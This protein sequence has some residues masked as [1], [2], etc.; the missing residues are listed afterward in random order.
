[1]TPYDQN[2]FAPTGSLVFYANRSPKLFQ[3]SL[4]NCRCVCALDGV[5]FQERPPSAALL[6]PR[7]IRKPLNQSRWGQMRY[8]F[9]R[10][11]YDV[12]RCTPREFFL[13]RTILFHFIRQS[14]IPRK[15]HRGPSVIY[16]AFVRML[17]DVIGWLID[18]I[19]P[20]HLRRDHHSLF[21]VLVPDSK[22]CASK[23]EN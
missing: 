1:M 13:F 14:F 23:V 20:L 21:C 16:V 6:S 17:V 18:C 7:L 19:T 15:H 12:Y 10:V 2:F 5:D 11:Q 3:S 22:W 9:V 8:V 4:L